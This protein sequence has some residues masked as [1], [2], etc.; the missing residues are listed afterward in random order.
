MLET[1]FSR[2]IKFI[3]DSPDTINYDYMKQLSRGIVLISTDNEVLAASHL[4][5]YIL[6]R[7]SHVT[8]SLDPFRLKISEKTSDP[9]YPQYLKEYFEACISILSVGSYA[10]VIELN[11]LVLGREQFFEKIILFYFRRTR[12]FKASLFGSINPLP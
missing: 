3:T 1:A 9:K 4:K 12:S 7:N 11:I 6:S 8:H 5:L 10:F 2:N